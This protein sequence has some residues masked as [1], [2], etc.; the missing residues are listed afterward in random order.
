LLAG[1]ALCALG[2]AAVPGVPAWI[3]FCRHGLTW[4][5]QFAGGSHYNFTFASFAAGVFGP[6]WTARCVGGAA[7]LGL[8]AWTWWQCSRRPAGS[9]ETLCLLLVATVMCSMVAWVHYLVWLMYPLCVLAARRNWTLLG[10][11]LVC[12]NVAGSN[13]FDLTSPALKLLN[14]N[15]PLFVMAWC[16]AHF[17]RVEVV[18]A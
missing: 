17:S 1:T 15:L 9:D 14:A 6:G 4:L 3:S 13:P 10:V 12:V 7:S 11:T 18:D 8:I 5:G 2:W 16:Y